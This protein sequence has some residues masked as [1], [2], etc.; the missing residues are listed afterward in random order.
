MGDIVRP[1]PGSGLAKRYLF[2]QSETSLKSVV[3]SIVLLIPE[4]SYYVCNI[5]SQR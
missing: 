5:A 3:S 4:G 1:Q 2:K